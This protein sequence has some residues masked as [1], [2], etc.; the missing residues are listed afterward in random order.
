MKC[1]S[2][3]KLRKIQLCST[4]LHFMDKIDPGNESQ[5][6]LKVRIFNE[7]ME[8]GFH[9]N[10]QIKMTML[11]AK[12]DLGARSFK[13]GRGSKDMLAALLKQKQELLAQ[14]AT[15]KNGKHWPLILETIWWKIENVKGDDNFTFS[16]W[17][18]WF[19]KLTLSLRSQYRHCLHVCVYIKLK[20]SLIWLG[21]V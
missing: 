14:L 19:L 6:K 5:S 16:R 12:I 17:M 10:V 9:W 1:S 8:I 18:W 3:V 4:V 21:L 13:E 7:Y 11:E 20:H 2:T 15:K